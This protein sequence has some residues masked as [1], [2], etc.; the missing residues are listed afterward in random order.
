M[1]IETC[2]ETQLNMNRRDFIAV[3]SGAGLGILASGGCTF[4]GEK[5][6]LAHGQEA[7]SP[8]LL[9]YP[10]SLLLTGGTMRLGVPQ[11][12]GGGKQSPTGAVAVESLRRYLPAH[13]LPLEVRLGSVQSG[14]DRSWLMPEE[15]EFI[16]VTERPE[17][18]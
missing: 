17:A 16:L 14:Y 18:R 4:P 15:N 13:G 8:N 1:R 10:Q 12:A 9:P 7:H 2:P 5:A 11:P 6:R 3:T